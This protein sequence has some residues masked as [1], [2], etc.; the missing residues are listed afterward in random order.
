MLPTKMF[1]M[2]MSEILVILLVAALFLG[3]EKLPDAASKIS[4]GI[5]DLRK[6]TKDLTDTIENDT[7]IGG[8][9]RELKSALRGDELRRPIALKKPE[10]PPSAGTATLEPGAVG[11][12]I[13]SGEADATTPSIADAGAVAA[14]PSVDANGEAATGAPAGGPGADTSADPDAAEPDATRDAGDPL[15]LIRPAAGTAKRELG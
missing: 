13:G 7:E 11:A 15:R 3:P 12:A 4:K 9:I 8:A 6:Q 5:R 2:G 1:G 14:S 10:P